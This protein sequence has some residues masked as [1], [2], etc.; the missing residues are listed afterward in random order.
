MTKPSEEL[1]TL[2][3]EYVNEEREKFIGGLFSMGIVDIVDRLRSDGYDPGDRP[4]AWRTVRRVLREFKID[5]YGR[6]K[7][8]LRFY[9]TR[10]RD[11]F[12]GYTTEWDKFYKNGSDSGVGAEKEL[13]RV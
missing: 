6:R 2:V 8:V 13:T 5:E 1:V 3:K 9:S 11:K 7:K 12:E 10:Q 4:T